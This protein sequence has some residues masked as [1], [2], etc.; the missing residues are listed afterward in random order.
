MKAGPKITNN[1][2]GMKV[3][4]EKEDDFLIRFL[5]EQGTDCIV[6]IRAIKTDVALCVTKT[7]EKIPIVSELEKKRK[8]LYNSPQQR[9]HFPLF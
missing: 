5:W 1:P 8:Y 3:D 7:P 6:D 2:L 4:S 9:H